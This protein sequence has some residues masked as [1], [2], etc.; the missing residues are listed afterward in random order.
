MFCVSSLNLF[1]LPLEPGLEVMVT[2]AEMLTVLQC[3]GTFMFDHRRHRDQ[4][5]ASLGSPLRVGPCGG[6][7]SGPPPEQYRFGPSLWR[8]LDRG[9]HPGVVSYCW[10]PGSRVRGPPRSATTGGSEAAGR[11]G[12]S[13]LPR[14]NQSFFLETINSL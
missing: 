4:P 8:G 3:V 1:S 12:I 5:G 6:A 7:P 11:F 10:R 2:P 9:P 13:S 14:P